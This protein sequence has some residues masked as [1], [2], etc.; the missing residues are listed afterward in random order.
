MTTGIT[1]PSW[2]SYSWY[3]HHRFL[4]SACI[5]HRI[6]QGF[7][8]AMQSLE[9]QK[10]I[11]LHQVSPIL[12]ALSAGLAAITAATSGYSHVAKN[13]AK[14][15]LCVLQSLHDDS[16]N[17]D[18]VRA[19]L[20][21]SLSLSLALCPHSCFAVLNPSSKESHPAMTLWTPSQRSR[22][23][24]ALFPCRT[25]LMPLK[26][27][28]SLEEDRSQILRKRRLFTARSI[29]YIARHPSS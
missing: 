22:Y 25:L 10:N 19:A 21:T 26:A 3:V 20:G 24:S 16:L 7:L 17:D 28:L 9:E 4:S 2:I 15:G 12:D 29:T 13:A 1:S 5:P 8:E 11:F 6:I 23:V 27:P 14:R 18:F